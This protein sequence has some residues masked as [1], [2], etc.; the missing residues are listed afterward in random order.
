GQSGKLRI[1]L[2]WNTTDDLDLHII[3]PNG[4][5]AYNNK[6]VENRGIIGQLDVDKNAGGDIVS[7]P[8]ENINFDR[9]PIGLHKIY[10]N[11]YAVRERNEV[12]FT[13]TIMPENGEGRIFNCLV[14][15]K[16]TNKNIATFEYKNGELVFEELM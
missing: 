8:Q 13:V 6:I 11:L 12:P 14:A 10:V 1:N 3:T 4:E 5:I 7:N 9:M 15:G 2:A 16:G